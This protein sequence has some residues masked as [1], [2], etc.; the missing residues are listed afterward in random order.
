MVENIGLQDELFWVRCSFQAQGK[1]LRRR[2]RR[3]STALNY[4]GKAAR[5]GSGG[6]GDDSDGLWTFWLLAFGVWL[7]VFGLGPLWAMKR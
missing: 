2:G 3:R 5:M 7:L 4:Q 1:L 6:M